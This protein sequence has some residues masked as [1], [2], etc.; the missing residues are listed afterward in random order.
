MIPDRPVNLLTSSHTDR[1]THTPAYKETAVKME[2]LPYHGPSPLPR[3]NFRF[4]TVHP[5]ARRGSGTQMEA[6]RLSGTGQRVGTDSDEARELTMAQPIEFRPTPQDSREAL[7][8]RLEAAPLEHVEALLASYD[9]LQQLHDRGILDLFRGVLGAGDEIVLQL[10]SVLTDPVTVRGLRNLVLMA[11]ILGNLNP[12]VL[13]GILREIPQSVD[14]KA[15]QDPPSTFALL[16][17]MTSP[18]A[19]RGLAVTAALLEGLG[20][21]LSSK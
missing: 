1:A 20:R 21:G 11:Q 2:V 8:R 12:E 9:L 5:A 7:Q 18:D 4:G 6:R 15:D 19:R 17:R 14:Q 3:I 10:T 13:H 16:G